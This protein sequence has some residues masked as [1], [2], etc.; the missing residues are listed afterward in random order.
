[1]GEEVKLENTRKAKQVAKYNAETEELLQV[2]DSA[3]EA[4]VDNNVNLNSLYRVLTKKSG[5]GLGFKWGY[6]DGQINET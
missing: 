6:Y 5:I 1:M 3:K 2:Y 4:A